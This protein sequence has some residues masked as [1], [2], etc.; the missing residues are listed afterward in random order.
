MNKR[1]ITKLTIALA[2]LQ[3]A[4]DLF[5][6][7]R[8]YICAA[9]LA[10]A[11]EEI[12]GTYA[13]KTD[14]ENAFELLCESVINDHK[15]CLPKKEIGYHLNFYRNELKHFNIPENEELELDPETEAA[16]LILRSLINLVIHGQVIT[17][18]ANKFLEWMQHN[19]QDMFA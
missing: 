5:L 10:G 15:I 19:R 13:K 7:D 16:T 9:T 1:K 3:T 6:E 2:Q 17:N 14:N 11:A 8:N 18:N 4:I 12:L